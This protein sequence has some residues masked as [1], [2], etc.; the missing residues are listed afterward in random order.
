MSIDK[1]GRPVALSGLRRAERAV[2]AMLALE[3]RRVFAREELAEA[4]FGHL[5]PDRTSAN[6]RVALS[7]LRS[8]LGDA[9]VIEAVGSGYRLR[10]GTSVDVVEFDERADAGRA[11]QRA[12]Q[13]ATAR[14]ELTAALALY[15]ADLLSGDASFEFASA[16]RARLR[17]RHAAALEDLADTQLGLGVPRDAAATLERAIEREPT[18]ESAYRRLMTAHYAA[19]EQDAALR[20]YE[21]CRTILSDEL[22]VDPLPETMTLH[23]RILRREPI[24]VPGGATKIATGRVSPLPFVARGSER[25]V[26]ES[27]LARAAHGGVFVLLVGEPGAGKTRLVEESLRGRT[28]V[29]VLWTRCFELERDLPFQPLWDALGGSLA[30]GDE[31]SDRGRGALIERYARAV[32]AGDGRPVVWVIDDV[33]W[34][35]YSTLEVLHFIA[36]RSANERIAIVAVGH[37]DALPPEHA[38]SRILTDLRREGRAE[39][40]ALMPLAVDDVNALARATG[41]PADAARSIHARSGGNAF[42]VA[43]LVM[44]AK[45]GTMTLPETARDAV[46][47]RVRTLPDHARSS[48][49]AASVLGGKFQ[50]REVAVVAQLDNE[51]TARALGELETHGLLHQLAAGEQMLAHQ[52]VR[53]AVYG[54]IP[55]TVRRSMHERAIDAVDGARGADGASLVCYHAELAGDGECAFACAVSAGERALAREAG[56][57]ALASFDRALRQ[58]CDAA[59][60]ERCEALRAEARGLLDI[61]N[62]V[63][64]PR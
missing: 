61:G 4:V 28:D 26:L 58:P 36:R 63:D 14:N 57:E 54:A 38:A 21:R 59:A 15:P 3:P 12:G 29:R 7:R 34:A 39:R 56:A 16:A 27:A 9:S 2:L 6:L 18:R 42:F 13:F 19:G 5:E 23:E 31:R 53:D 17:E 33:Q 11:A 35:D 48:L 64:T 25:I 30:S 47:A 43:E 52:L 20:A 1:D 62:A 49:D 51:T 45:R 10:S 55:A 24:T 40:I 37:A 50:A 32:L 41:V 22:G 46:L 8:A 44:A 60:R